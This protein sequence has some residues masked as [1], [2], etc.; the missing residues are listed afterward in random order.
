M[1]NR[2]HRYPSYSTL[3]VTLALIG[4]VVASVV[5]A[6]EVLM[7]LFLGILFGILLTKLRNRLSSKTN[8]KPAVSLT[9]VVFGFLLLAVAGG[10]VFFVQINS[11]AKRIADQLDRSA[12]RLSDLVDRY[13]VAQAVFNSVPLL[14]SAV[15]FSRATDKQ[16]TAPEAERD[17]GRGQSDAGRND[18]NQN[19]T[20]D[21]D[22]GQSNEEGDSAVSMA[23]MQQPLQKLTA[24][25]QKLFKTTFGLVVNCLLIFFVGLFLASSPQM[26]VNGT[27]C[28]FPA[29][30]RPRAEQVLSQLGH[31]LWRWLL[32]R[33]ATMTITGFGAFLVM[34]IVGVPMATTIGIITGLLCFIPNIGAAIALL[35]AI[36]AALPQGL[37]QVTAVVI[38]YISLQMV[39]SYIITPL[40]QQRQ[41]AMPPAM[42]LAFQ[43][44]LG[45][46]LGFI[47]A[48]IASPLLATLMVITK[49]L[50]VEDY[51]GD[52]PPPN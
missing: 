4:L 10:V 39:E 3:L 11:E 28:L 8:I 51:L 17:D 24:S 1:S 46:L 31:T 26:Y 20:G 48:A 35:L 18:G 5:L 22:G 7:I 45:A 50:Y 30:Y 36:L 21:N 13:P 12:G 37:T 9:L 33:F 19:A 15:D 47:G 44:F 49:M 52:D 41:V 42:L 2:N 43:A 23:A 40:I 25:I 27:V 38:G 6:S 14:S 29:P 16:E 32:G 34:F